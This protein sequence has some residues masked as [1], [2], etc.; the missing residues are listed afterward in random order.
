MKVAEEIESWNKYIQSVL[1]A[2]WTKKL[3]ILKQS[4]YKLVY[5]RKLI[6]VIDYRPYGGTIIEKLLE[7]M[8]KVLQLREMARRTIRKA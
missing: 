6:L 5:R 7:I 3:R 1:F 8:N 4:S 2:Y